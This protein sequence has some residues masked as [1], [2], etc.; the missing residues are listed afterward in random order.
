M[1]PT[2]ESGSLLLAMAICDA[3]DR[4]IGTP[5]NEAK[6]GDPCALLYP[7]DADR[8]AICE[9]T[10]EPYVEVWGTPAGCACHLSPPCPACVEAPLACATCL[11]T[12]P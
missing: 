6:P 4:P 10:L 5:A 8:S 1:K 11:E 9:G 12:V 7:I 3:L 2:I